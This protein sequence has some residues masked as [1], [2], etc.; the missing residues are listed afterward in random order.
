MSVKAEGGDIMTESSASTKMKMG[1][2]FETTSDGNTT[3]RA[4]RID[5]KS[6]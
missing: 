1:A 4:P 5:F 3:M 2:T 6:G